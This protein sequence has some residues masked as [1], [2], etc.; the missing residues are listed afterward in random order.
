MDELAKRHQHALEHANERIRC[1]V[2]IRDIDKTG[3]SGA[4]LVADVAVY[5][6]GKAVISWRSGWRG[7]ETQDSFA[8]M[9][10][11]HGHHGATRFIPYEEFYKP[12]P[13]SFIPPSWHHET[14]DDPAA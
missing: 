10:A 3:V 4:G 5:P 13:D 2:V 11:V 8:D 9:V 12:V 1:Y 7:V 6:N 14:D